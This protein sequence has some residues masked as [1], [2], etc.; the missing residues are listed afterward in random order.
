VQAQIKNS[1]NNILNSVKIGWSVDGIV[2]SPV[3]YTTPINTLG[4]GFGNT[5]TISLG[6]V[7]FANVPRVIKVWTYL[8]NGNTDVFPSD[9][10]ATVTLRSSLGGVYTIGGT[11]PDYPTIQ[12]AITDLN[13]YGVCSAVTFNIRNG[14]YTTN[15]YVLKPVQGMSAV[16]RVTFQSE[17]NN[18]ANVTVSYNVTST[19]S[20]YV[21]LFD[22]GS[23]FTFR[24]LTVNSS[25]T[26]YGYSFEFRGTASFDSVVGCNMVPAGSTSSYTGGV[27]AISPFK[28]TDNE[29]AGNTITGGY[30][31]IYL[32]GSALT[33]AIP[34]FMIDNNNITNWYYY[35]I[36]AQYTRNTK[37]RG[38]SVINNTTP[39]TSYRYGVYCYY[40][41]DGLEV[42]NNTI[43]ITNNYYLYGLYTYYAVG[44]ASNTA[45]QPRITGNNLNLQQTST[46]YYL[47]PYYR[48]YTAYDSFANNTLIGTS[49]YY[50]YGYMNM[51]GT[52]NITYNNI[53][54]LTNSGTGSTYLYGQYD[55]A[56]NIASN[57]TYI[58]NHSSSA[59]LYNYSG[60]YGT[61][62]VFQNNTVNVNFTGTGTVYFYPY[63]GTNNTFR[64]N[65]ITSATTTGGNYFY[66]LYYT[67][68][69]SFLN[70]N[71]NMST[72]SGLMYGA[73]GYQSSPTY[74]G[75]TVAGN[76]FNLT[77]TSGG[78][79][80]GVY[81]SYMYG[82]NV[83]NNIVYCQ[84]TGSIYALYTQYSTNT[85]YYNNT[86]H[87][88]GT[89][90]TNYAGYVYNTGSTYSA[91]IRNNIFSKTS[92]NGYV[93]YNYNP[94]FAS[95]DFNNIYT[96][97]GTNLYQTS[98]AN[99]TT[100]QQIR[101]GTGA[102]LNSIVYDP[103]YTSTTNL[104][105][106]VNN[107]ASWSLQGRGE[108]AGFNSTDING[109]ARAI[110]KSA[111]VPDIGPYEFT[112][113]VAPP[114]ATA[115][116]AAP[117][118]GTTQVFTLGQDTVATV[119][120]DVSATVPSTITV[121]QYSGIQPP[122]FIAS[123][124]M[125]IYTDIEIPSGTPLHSTKFYYK[126]P[127]T[128][129]TIGEAGLRQVKKD[130]SNPWVV[131]SSPQ[132]SNNPV[133]NWNY[134]TN[135]TTFGYHTLTDVPNNAATTD[136]MSPVT[137]F[138]APST[139]TVKVKIKNNGNNNINS[140][141][142]GWTLNGVPQTPISYT[143][144][145][146][147]LGSPQ[148]NEAIITLGNVSFPTSAGI[149]FVAYTYSPNGVT[150][151]A[152]G[153]DTLKFT[154]KPSLNGTY[155]IGGTTPDY[156]TVVD[157][158]KDLNQFGICGPV[159]FNIRDGNYTDG[160]K[161][162][163]PLQGS[164]AINRVTFQSETG[165]AGNCVITH[166]G[167]ST[168]DNY[169]FGLA[170]VSYISLKNL[171][172][173][174]TGSTYCTAID[175]TGSSS[176][177]TIK[178]CILQGPSVTSTSQYSSMILAYSSFT[179]SYNVILKDSILNG[180][181]GIYLYSG[182]A[183]TNNIV[184]SN[185]IGGGYYGGV[186][187]YYTYGTKF[188]GNTVNLPSTN[189]YYGIGM[190]YN[191]NAGNTTSDIIG[192]T[193]NFNGY[194]YAT[195]CY[196]VTGT[197]TTIRGKIAYNNINVNSTNYIYNYLGIYGN[198]EDM[199]NNNIN[200]LSSY[201]YNYMGYY[202]SYATV[203]DNKFNMTGN[204]GFVYNYLGYNMSYSQMYNNDININGLYGYAWYPAYSYNSKIYNNVLN[205]SFTGASTSY[206]LYAP[207]TNSDTF[208][209]NTIRMTNA[210]AS[211]Y[212]AYFYFSGYSG[213]YVR[214]NIFANLSTTG[215]AYYNV[216]GGT[217]SS[218]YNNIYSANGNHINGTTGTLQ[219]WR[220]SS[221]Y[222]LNSLCYDPGFT[223]ATDLHPDP[224]NPN[225]WSVNGRGIHIPGLTTDRDGNTRVTT[226]AAGVPDLGAYEFVPN[227]TPPASAA[228][229]ATP[230]VGKQ[231]F[232][233]GQDTVAVLDWQPNSQIPNAVTVR[234]YTG[235]VGPN[236]PAPGF[237]YFYT[238]ISAQNSTY[239]FNA[240]VYYKDPWRGT[241]GTEANLRMIKKL[242]PNPWQAY[243]GSLSA[244]DAT[245]NIITAP[246]TNLGMITGIDDG[247]LFSAIIT[248]TGNL[249]FCPGG[250]V[251][252]NANTG[253]GY[254]YQW[255]YNSNIIP[256]ATGSSYTATA[257]GDYSV[258]ITD[259]N[260]VTATSLSVLV[261]IIAPPAAQVSASGPL[262]YCPGGTLTLYAAT[263]P[264]QSYQWY[265]N[266]NLI[267]G[268]TNPSYPVGTAGNYTVTVKN[269]GCSSSS[270]AQVISDG[271]LT[272]NLGQDTSFCESGKPLILNAG[273]TGASYTW[274]GAGAGN[275][276]QTLSIYS[277]NQSGTY[278]V[279]VDAGPNCKAW[280][281][282]NVHVDPLPSVNGISY[283]RNG[284]TYYFA[285]SGQQDVKS[286][287]WLYS[288]GASD[289]AMKPTHTF[290]VAEFE[291]KLIVF[292]DCGTDT[293]ILHL[294][295]A[296]DNTPQG[297]AHYS[298]YP[299]PATTQITLSAEGTK[300]SDVTVI[301][302][303][304][305]VVYRGTSTEKQR[306]HKCE[307]PCQ[308]PLY[309]PRHSNRRQHHQ[310][311]FQCGEIRITRN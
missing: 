102:E 21:V 251:V 99:Y 140:V 270:P 126:D 176:Y 44:D 239:N 53:Y 276:G 170:N 130:G 164:S 304:G 26:S 33:T 65:T 121:Q 40:T 222:E 52:N 77:S 152:P 161:I 306:R 181:Y 272:V 159:V 148:G 175:M 310:Q 179:G 28:G 242:N 51:Y 79:I 209:N 230:A 253:T 232:T 290:A 218:D 177:D 166:A 18:A 187:M 1:G 34:R 303:L 78:T 131:F 12:A 156:P 88:A 103:A 70:N 72:T 123:N 223:S 54:N 294:P 240:N 257:Q 15:Q 71:I 308:W 118:A 41:Y 24:N 90:G 132:S 135:Q 299:N 292:N 14:S 66:M 237:M 160:G 27:Y 171:K 212:A 129:S 46:S 144:T 127:Q 220:T 182:G 136:L 213:N 234:Q 224:N 97:A 57:N 163:S 42:R 74:T 83:Y 96:A 203:H 146:Y 282:I 10:T 9:D 107:P 221:G 214:N 23:Y 22:S 262:T 120:W 105:P 189:A 157:A 219:A 229:P 291:V 165:N 172:L 39:T 58:V 55:G 36:Y 35:G 5:A 211:A 186:Y 113:N 100:L 185:Y 4:S 153:D 192:N 191:Y 114:N 67:T 68:N 205:V 8:P 206:G 124:P 84:S 238:D 231:V 64:N 117:A 197:S 266:G 301:D 162:N 193:L 25:N 37:I 116:P 154:I 151:P 241:T 85:N 98:S 296:I 302:G 30:Y 45:L 11:A 16:N 245:R 198:Y 32:N 141:N 115:V 50:I 149:N 143:S 122:S 17:T 93:Y 243:N 82:V 158:I 293:S 283:N 227:S 13:S 169:V 75:G 137:A 235:T 305:Q 275:N 277:K 199:Y 228:T 261:T 248:P 104:Q 295:L 56:N 155:T 47:Y 174:T 210:Y 202:A 112:P 92:A 108:H 76:K 69:C 288:D 194:G 263:A 109:N 236:F 267:T 297:D 215:G 217:N 178:G 60:A 285:P 208:Y 94:A 200:I 168:G 20:N 63:Y 86:F 91:N 254:S 61:N 2:Q 274:G 260:N 7:T 134:T 201:F 280:D 216:A 269:Q 173:V 125:Y 3:T 19:T 167:T 6:N 62:N 255:Y 307:Q 244:T 119:S 188:R 48:Y 138:C 281:T 147:T 59:Y 183:A 250:S 287:L 49:A 196:Y 226:L 258:K 233:F 309:D 252:L 207:Y 101:T 29:I 195:Y 43:N 73:Y 204:G 265:L 225:A 273:A 111:G 286:Y 284:S 300:F 31:G 95:S 190:Y 81:E 139:Q 264:N 184:D 268:A 142:I 80:Y 145:I 106:N 87:T 279:Y 180:S 256:G 259:I 150:D 278:W 110:V 289:T 89:S 38:N 246:L 271:P 249:I 311:A 128:G 247:T 298:L 133:L